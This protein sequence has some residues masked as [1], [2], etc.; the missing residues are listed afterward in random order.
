MTSTSSASRRACGRVFPEPSLRREG[1]RR[2]GGVASTQRKGSG[3]TRSPER[4]RAPFAPGTGTRVAARAPH[5]DASS[6]LRALPRQDSAPGPH[7]ESGSRSSGAGIA[8]HRARDQPRDGSG[9]HEVLEAG[10]QHGIAE[11]PRSSRT[12]TARSAGTRSIDGSPDSE[13]HLVGPA[14]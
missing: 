6:S 14:R 8:C 4:R 3:L 10:D 13:L 11:Q 12:A 9:P 1:L 5:A 2:A 7:L